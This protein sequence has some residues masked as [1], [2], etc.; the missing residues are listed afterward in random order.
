MGQEGLIIS[1]FLSGSID[2][3]VTII[4]TIDH[5]TVFLI[6]TVV[7]WSKN[8]LPQDVSEVNEHIVPEDKHR[9]VTY[10]CCWLHAFS[11]CNNSNVI[12]WLL[13]TVHHP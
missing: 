1:F 8:F 7:T 12:V 9:S 2:I 6:S 10:G 13:P 3:S 11:F 4:I 5:W